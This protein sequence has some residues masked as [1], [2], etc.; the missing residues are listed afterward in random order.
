MC[1][2]LG[3]IHNYNYRIDNKDFKSLNLLN[4]KRGPD[5]QSILEYNASNFKVLLGHTRLS[6]QDLSNTANQPMESS[7]GR[8]IISFNGEI[9]NHF[10][11]RKFLNSKY[12]IDW[13][14][15]SDTE[16]FVNLFDYFDINEILNMSEGMFSFILLDKKHYKVTFARDAAGEKPIYI[17]F[18]NSYFIASSDLTSIKSLSTFQENINHHALSKYFELN[19]VPNP[20]TIYENTFKLPPAT[21]LTINCNEFEYIKINNFKDLYNIK[22]VECKKWWKINLDKEKYK[23]LDNYQIKSLVHDSLKTSIKNQLISDVPL[24]AF[25]SGG[26]DSALVVS[27]MQSLQSNTNTFTIGYENK[28]YDESS[29]AK[30]IADYLSTNHTSY[31][32]SNKE[33]FNFLENIPYAYSEPF[34]DSSQLP[35]LLVSKLAK[36]KVK[37]VLTGD[38]GDELFGGYNRYIYANKYWKY[39]NFIN[40]FL[41]KIIVSSSLNISPKLFS[42]LLNKI[43]NLNISNQSINKVRAKLN[44]INDEL[45]Y[46]KSITNEWNNTD[47]LLKNNLNKNEDNFLK[48]IYNYNINFEEKMMLSDFYTYLPDDILC[49]VDR[50][51]MYNSLESRAPF[52]NKDLIEMAFNLPFENKLAKGNSK[53]ILKEIL[54]EYLP[55]NLLNKTKR[56]FGVPIGDL[57]R[58]DLKKW[59]T[60]I[61]SKNECQKHNLF[62]Y[63]VVE[64]T[65]KNHFEKKENNQFKLWSLVQFNLWYNHSKN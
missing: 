28:D 52:L 13:K 33:I 54:N 30:Y 36:E 20:N 39:F 51:T 7:S 44:N 43:F 63:N 32:F 62:N 1:G 34:A 6:I 26:I 14:S 12:K 46:Y 59:T 9:Y 25:L 64:K 38:G 40:P 49:K 24:G 15:T 2:I 58:K 41:R 19:Y 17:H 37:V 48:D 60:D 16:T 3:L 8:Y 11:L 4:I 65:L 61:L 50:A 47:K 35:T 22:S 18:N 27:I 23:K 45:S 5:H 10:H 21:F 42:L 55:Q 29:Q 31:I 56:G 53:I 57:I